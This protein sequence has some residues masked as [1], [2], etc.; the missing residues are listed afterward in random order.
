MFHKVFITITEK[1]E[2]GLLAFAVSS[3]RRKN[4]I[5]CIIRVQTNLGKILWRADTLLGNDLE[6]NNE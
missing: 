4:T 1:Y 3:D 6:T 5:S 2:D